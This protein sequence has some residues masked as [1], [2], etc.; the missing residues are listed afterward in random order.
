MTFRLMHKRKCVLS[1]SLPQVSGH[2]RIFL[3]RHVNE[4]SNLILEISLQLLLGNPD[5]RGVETIFYQI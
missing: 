1:I 2:S 5:S 4:G 3:D